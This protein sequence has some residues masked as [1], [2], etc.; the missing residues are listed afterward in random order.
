VAFVSGMAAGP[1]S[2]AARAAGTK[3]AAPIAPN[4]KADFLRND[5]R[6]F[7]LFVC[8]IVLAIVHYAVL[9]TAENS[10]PKIIQLA[11]LRRAS[12]S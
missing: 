9:F 1:P 10:F 11:S 12:A 3:E 8:F 5:L 4:P 7:R 6:E 2:I